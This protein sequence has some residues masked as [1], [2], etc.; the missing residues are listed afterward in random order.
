VDIPQHERG[1]PHHATSGRAWPSS[2]SHDSLGA[3]VGKGLHA[4]ATRRQRCDRGFD[5]AREFA[6]PTLALRGR[7]EV[8]FKAMAVAAERQHALRRRRFE[9]VGQQQDDDFMVLCQR[10]PTALRQR[11]DTAWISQQDEAR[12][13]PQQ[14]LRM[15]ERDG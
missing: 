7:R 13:G 1:I 15:I 14:S 9:R 8:Q 5:R 11:D 12:T 4:Y 6:Q 2:G 3:S 10:G